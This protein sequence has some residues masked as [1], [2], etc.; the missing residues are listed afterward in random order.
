MKAP[1]MSTPIKRTRRPGFGAGCSMGRAG[2]GAPAA[3]R[4]GAR[5]MAMR[6]APDRYRMSGRLS[7]ARTVQLRD[8]ETRVLEVLNRLNGQVDE[9]FVRDQQGNEIEG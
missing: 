7:D 1:L 4:A 5:S 3:K 2:T 8:Q 9:V 6:T